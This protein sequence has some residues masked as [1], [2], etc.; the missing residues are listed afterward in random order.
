MVV[1][2]EAAESIPVE[3]FA[4]SDTVY[5]VFAVSPV[6]VNEFPLYVWVPADGV[7]VSV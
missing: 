6:K 4:L 3:F 5:T 1:V 2:V 7:I